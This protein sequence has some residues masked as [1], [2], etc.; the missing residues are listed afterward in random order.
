MS[1][2]FKKTFV[3][4]LIQALVSG[5]SLNARPERTGQLSCCGGSLN[6]C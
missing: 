3:T 1:S 6:V 5:L 2:I 4:A